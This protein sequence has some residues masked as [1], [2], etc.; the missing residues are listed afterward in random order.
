VLADRFDW[1]AIFILFS[2]FFLLTN[3]IYFRSL[4]S[5]FSFYQINTKYYYINIGY[6]LA[7][8]GDYNN[9]ESSNRKSFIGTTDF[10]SVGP[11]SAYWFFE[12]TFSATSVTIVA[13]TL[14]ERCQMA[15]YLAYSVV[16]AGFIYP[17]VAHSIWSNEGFLSR[18]NNNPFMDQGVID[19]AGG[20]VVHLNGGLIALYATLV[21]GPRRGRFYD[22]QGEPLDNPQPFP[23]HSVALQLLG[24]MILWFGCKLK[25]CLFT[26]LFTCNNSL[27]ILLHSLN[28]SYSIPFHSL[29]YFLN[30]VRI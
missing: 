15:A 29:L 3:V 19:F 13:G 6:A 1:G 7:F 10:F 11:S 12:Y 17:V 25:S 28:L 5:P 14:A 27:S 16:L 30:R 9:P 4:P 8:G 23:G 18:T 24:T 20:G 21:L 2:F 22:A 26:F